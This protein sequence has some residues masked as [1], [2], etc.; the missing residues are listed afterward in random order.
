MIFVQVE[1]KAARRKGFNGE[2][3]TIFRINNAPNFDFGKAI[4]DLSQYAVRIEKYR[5]RI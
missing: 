4:S 2:R 3:G 5:D 1:R